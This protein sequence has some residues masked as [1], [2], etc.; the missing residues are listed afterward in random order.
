MGPIVCPETSVRHYHSA[1]REIPEKRSSHLHRG[2]SLKSRML[3]QVPQE[4]S[5]S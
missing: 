4:D 3:A 1:L 2:G 5:A